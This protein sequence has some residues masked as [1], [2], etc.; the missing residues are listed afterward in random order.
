VLGIN[1]RMD[2]LQ[3]AIVLAKLPLLQEELDQ[4]WRIGQELSARLSPFVKTQTIRPGIKS[5]YAQFTIEVEKRAEFQKKLQESGIPTAVHY[6][7]PLHLQ[8]AFAYMT[9]GRGTY[10]LS[11][12]ASDRVV[13]LPMHP[14]LDEPTIDFIV[15]SVEQALGN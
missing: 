3:A 5:P 10:P 15:S 13:S 11:E 14:Y 1:G 6:P 4:R 12:T 8:P 7:V 2:T 9:Q